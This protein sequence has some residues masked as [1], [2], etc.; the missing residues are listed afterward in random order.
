MQN[1]TCNILITGGTGFL[2]GHLI[3]KLFCKKHRI[4]LL[5]RKD[6]GQYR[7]H[8]NKLKI[9][10]GD[11]SDFDSLKKAT[12]GVDVIYHM[13]A[14]LGEWGVPDEDYHRV[15]VEGTKNLMTVS[16]KNTRARFVFAST[17]GVQGKGYPRAV[18]SLPYNPPYIY[19]KTKCEAE[20]LVLEYGRKI[21]MRVV[22]IR[23]DFVYGPGDY[24]RI[25]LYRA[26]QKKRFLCIG[27]GRARLHPTYID[28]AVQGLILA[29]FHPSASGVFNIAGPD[30]IAVR[31]YLQIIAAELDVK[32]P[33]L[34]IP[35]IIGLEAAFICEAVS[36]ILHRPPFISHSKVNFLTLDHGS[37]ISK[38]RRILGYD[39]KIS[40]TEGFQ[41]T[42]KWAV[43]NNL[44]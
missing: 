4:R 36:K 34:S 16:V 3:E 11:L 25:S 33:P 30:I 8:K 2:G 7:Y 10:V 29:G 17:P 39:P 35:K 12:D 43:V 22:I 24:R 28:D 42:K 23:P 15:N 18:E 5:V 6:K 37:D 20:K 40:F 38:A 9:I 27:N 26:I 1:N 19:E 14:Q 31:D 44:L 13:A 21:D 32:I 41:L